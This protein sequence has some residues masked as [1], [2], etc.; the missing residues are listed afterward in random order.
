MAKRKQVTETLDVLSLY[1]FEGGITHLIG[2][3]RGIEEAYDGDI[4]LDLETNYDYGGEYQQ[5]CIKRQ[6]DETNEERAKRLE[7]EKTHKATLE[8]NERKQYEKLKKKYG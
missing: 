2:M 8:E 4:Y 1:D 6:R 3:L 7:K 5:F